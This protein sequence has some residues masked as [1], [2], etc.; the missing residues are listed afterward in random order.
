[1][2]TLSLASFMPITALTCNYSIEYF[3]HCIHQEYSEKRRPKF[4][5]SMSDLMSMPQM[6]KLSLLHSWLVDSQHNRFVQFTLGLDC[7]L[8]FL[9]GQRTPNL[10]FSNSNLFYQGFNLSSISPLK[11][12]QSILGSYS[13]VINVLSQNITGL[14]HIGKLSDV[15]LTYSWISNLQDQLSED[16]PREKIARSSVTHS[17]RVQVLTELYRH[18]HNPSKAEF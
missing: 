15:C 3:F 7:F 16:S 6:S 9:K 13:L 1:M 10:F 18:C 17:T 2:A 8:S 12:K 5:E 4:G 11:A 14:Q